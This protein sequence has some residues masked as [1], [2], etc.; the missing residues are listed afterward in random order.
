[1][2]AAEAV[3]DEHKI[4]I[5]RAVILPAV[6][7]IPDCL[8]SRLRIGGAQSDIGGGPPADVVIERAVA[9]ELY[10]RLGLLGAVAIVL[11]RHMATRLDDLHLQLGKVELAEVAGHDK[12][13]CPLQ[14]L[15]GQNVA[16]LEVRLGVRV[17]SQPLFD[18]TPGRSGGALGRS[19]RGTTSHDGNCERERAEDRKASLPRPRKSPR[20][21][22]DAAADL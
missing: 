10:L 14:V 15:G 6:F 19:R 3:E 12:R 11:A 5:E 20:R 16:G 9:L 17:L 1:M 21:R 2:V 18:A 8:E 13:T 22:A 4:Q 7:E